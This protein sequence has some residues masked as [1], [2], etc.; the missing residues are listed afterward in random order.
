MQEAS[1]FPVYTRV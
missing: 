1:A